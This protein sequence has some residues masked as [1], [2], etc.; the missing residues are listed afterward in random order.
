MKLQAIYV[1]GF[2][3][4]SVAFCGTLLGAFSADS[5]YKY[6]TPGAVFWV[7]AAASA[8]GSGCAALIGF[9][10]KVYARYS[11]ALPPTPAPKNLPMAPE[12]AAALQT[13]K[14]IFK[15]GTKTDQPLKTDN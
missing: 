14:V 3:I 2:L 15:S 7:K 11:D 8:Y 4:F 13:D 5:V 9:R 6:V 12:L 10:S 1:D